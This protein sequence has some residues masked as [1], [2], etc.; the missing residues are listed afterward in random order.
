MNVHKFLVVL[1]SDGC[2]DIKS[3]E[4]KI[5]VNKMYAIL[6]LLRGLNDKEARAQDLKNFGPQKQIIENTTPLKYYDFKNLKKIS[7]MVCGDATADIAKEFAEKNF[8]KGD[9]GKSGR[10]VEAALVL[11]REKYDAE[12]DVGAVAKEIIDEILSDKNKVEAE[13]MM[14]YLIRQG[15]ICSK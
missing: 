2:N 6:A 10:S 15:D 1:F 11:L 5:R 13:N 4:S 7:D 3:S 14:K 9:N 8:K 12:S